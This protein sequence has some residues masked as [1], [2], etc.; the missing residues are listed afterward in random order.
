[1]FEDEINYH[2]L[3]LTERQR[4]EILTN[5]DETFVKKDKVGYVKDY[6]LPEWIIT[7]QDTEKK[8]RERLRDIQQR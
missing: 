6:Y 8:F 1:M 7:E 5:T 2:K 4:K 3:V